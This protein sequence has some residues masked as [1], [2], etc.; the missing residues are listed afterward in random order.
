MTERPSESGR[1]WLRL[2]LILIAVL[3]A[4][5]IVLMLLLLPMGMMGWGG[6]PGSGMILSPLLAIGMLGVFFIILLGG[7]VVLYR[8]VTEGSLSGTDR[9]LEELRL[10]YARGELSQEEFEQRRND[11][12][13]TER[14]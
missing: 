1:S 11:L 10:S 12:E 8:A 13:R 7:G 4:L 3:L 9:A 14:P 5:P 6:G 2:L